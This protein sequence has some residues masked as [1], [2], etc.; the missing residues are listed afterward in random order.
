VLASYN[1]NPQSVMTY[2]VLFQQ[3]G[4]YYGLDWRLLA[5]LAYRE[6]RLNPSAIGGSGEYG[7]MQILPSTWKTIAPNLG[8][9]D[10]FDAYSNAL[11][12]TAY[13]AYLRN[14][15]YSLGHSEE[16]W[17]LVA[18]NW[19]PNNVANL[20]RSG[21]GWGDLPYIR[22]KYVH[23]IFEELNQPNSTLWLNQLRQPVPGR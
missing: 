9:S 23:D 19:G 2:E 4:A 17:L 15:V 8:V 21:G 7:L 3:M 22:Q 14:Y 11:A 12:G 10:P 5:S 6:S 20:L 18:Y 13:L 16:Y 1:Y